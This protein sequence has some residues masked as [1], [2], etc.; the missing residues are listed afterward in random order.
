M[1]IEKMTD[2]LQQIEEKFLEL[3]QQKPLLVRSPGRVNLIGEHTDYNEG[4]VLPAAIN[5]SIYLALAPSGNDKGM[6]YAHDLGDWHHFELAA[7]KKASEGWPNYLLGVAD[8]FLKAGY[9]IPGF[10]CVFGGDIPI[11]A[12]LSSS[13][14]IE[15]GLSFALNELF[16]LHIEPLQLVRM[17]QK[18]EN[19]FVGVQCGIMDQLVNI[20]GKEGHVIQLD[21]RSLDFTYFPFDSESVRIVLCDTQVSH[22][23]AASE[24]NLRRKQCEAGVAV[25]R[26]HYPQV[27]SLRD[28][29]LEML[30][31][32]RDEFDPVVFKRCRYVIKENQRVL[33]ACDDLRN[34][35]FRSFGQRMIESHLGLQNEFEVS[36]KE[37]DQLFAAAVAMDGVLGARM[38]GAGFGGCTINLVET[39]FLT[40]FQARM[41]TVFWDKLGKP[42]VFYLAKIGSGTEI[43]KRN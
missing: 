39:D 30:E 6:L 20:F 29:D 7:L 32:H 38:M 24:Y 5:K 28:A 41:D 16:Q 36:C 26:K 19:E 1:R 15:A 22:K 9:P 40:E 25:L 14:A 42:S 27:R 33:L 8:Q 2:K 43:I 3:F 31:K 12:G 37:L 23:L 10:N 21:C 18:A 13:A 34:R 17:A 11:G 35:D 4:F